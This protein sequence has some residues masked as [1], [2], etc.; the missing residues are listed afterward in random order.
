M[1]HIYGYATNVRQRNRQILSDDFDMKKVLAKMVLWLLS[2]EQKQQ[3]VDVHSKLS[4]WLMN[5]FCQKLSL[6]MKHDFWLFPKVKS[7]LKG[8]RF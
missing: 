8:W 1:Y 3:H 4:S 5:N 6:E 7:A 2:D